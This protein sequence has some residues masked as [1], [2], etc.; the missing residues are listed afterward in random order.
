L[1]KSEVAT[2]TNSNERI[3]KKYFYPMDYNLNE[4]LTSSDSFTQGIKNLRKGHVTSQVIQTYTEKQDA[5][6]NSPS[7]LGG[8]L[9]QFFGTSPFPEKLYEI[10]S[11]TPI[12]GSGQIS[13]SNDVAT[14]P[15]M[16]TATNLFKRTSNGNIIENRFDDKI[17]NAYIWA[18]NNQ[19]MVASVNN[20]S[21]NDIAC[22]GFTKDE[23]GGGWTQ[24]NE[25]NV[26]ADLNVPN[27][28]AYN[29]GP[30]LIKTGLTTSKSYVVELSYKAGSAISIKPASG[31][32]P[33]VV[34]PTILGWTKASCV[35]ANTTTLTV[36]GTGQ[37]DNL[38]IYP[39]DAQMTAY[40][41]DP[42]IG[43]TSTTDAKGRATYYEYDSFLRL[44]DI[45]DQNGN[46]VKK[47]DYHYQGQ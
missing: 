15:A 26:V 3:S 39:A 38:R 43:V 18:Y 13:V 40:T 14:I 9:L 31:T 4:G 16:Y 6:G 19:Y 46:I 20:A 25:S 35:V 47:F 5:T 41:Y 32:I 10:Q 42:L 37:I 28:W 34:G 29:L 22:T 24:Y 11:S 21:S 2:T 23:G 36:A 8:K 45:K 1:E 12:S 33:L 17:S 27:N 30:D 44:K 7:I